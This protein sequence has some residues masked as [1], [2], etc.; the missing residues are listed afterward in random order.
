M[1]PS[2]YTVGKNKADIMAL[3][4]VPSA[5]S[6]SLQYGQLGSILV[7]NTCGTFHRQRRTSINR[8][9]KV[10]SELPIYQVPCFRSLIS[11]RKLCKEPQMK[12]NTHPWVY[13][14]YIH[15]SPKGRGGTYGSRAHQ[16][17]PRSRCPHRTPRSGGC[18]CHCHSGSPVVSRWAALGGQRHRERHQQAQVTYTHAAWKMHGVLCRMGQHITAVGMH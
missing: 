14:C 16:S 12:K 11:R 6:A 2:A 10:V 9:R 3:Y 13:W 15:M 8:D 5:T 17:H 4:T 7:T 18:I 1:T